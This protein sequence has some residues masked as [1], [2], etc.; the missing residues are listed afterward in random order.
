MCSYVQYAELVSL[1]SHH[2]CSSVSRCSP[3]LASPHWASDPPSYK[4][5]CPSASHSASAASPPSSLMLR[6]IFTDFR[7]EQSILLCPLLNTH[8]SHRMDWK[9]NGCD[10][11]VACPFLTLS[12]SFTIAFLISPK[13]SRFEQKNLNEKNEGNN[14]YNRKIKWSKCFCLLRFALFSVEPKQKKTK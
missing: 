1:S 11:S 7:E 5:L 9:I 2:G 6:S 14:K 13:C 10:H 12:L 8:T 3:G 4:V